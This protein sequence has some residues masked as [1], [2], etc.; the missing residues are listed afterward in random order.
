MD[1]IDAALVDLG[2]D[3]FQLLHNFRF[4]I[5][6]ALRHELGNLCVPGQNEIDRL[7][8]ADRTLGRLFAQAANALITDS[9]LPRENIRAIGSHGQTIRHRPNQGANNFTLQIGDPS[10]IAQ[11]TGL[12]T[13][14]DFRRRDIAAGGQGAPLAPAFHRAAFSS[15]TCNRVIV[16]IGGMAN[17]TSLNTR[18]TTTGFDTGPGNILMDAWTQRH[19]NKPYDEDGEWAD[20]GNN[21]PALLAQLLQH[22]Y[23]KKAAPNSTG[24]EEF[25]FGWLESQL[26]NSDHSPADVQATLLEL[27][28][29]TIAEAIVTLAEPVNEIYVCGGGAYNKHLMRR[30]EHLLKPHRIGTTQLLG[31]APAWVECAAFA[32]LAKQT[33]AGLPGNLPTVTG[34]KHEVILGAIYPA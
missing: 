23:F 19:L 6:A 22:S 3:Q 30:L 14:A 15:N 25:N 31:I 17:I 10:T 29:T 12:T 27:T 8:A 33:L 2:N 16:N 24:R 28:A 11:Q 5:P 20:S 18:S 9:K 21:I 7:G 1:S 13:V 32:W 4:D 34:A 26:I